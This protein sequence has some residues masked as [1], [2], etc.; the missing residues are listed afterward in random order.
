MTDYPC[1]WWERTDRLSEFEDGVSSPIYRNLVTGVETSSQWLPVGALYVA[2]RLPTAGPHDFPPVGTDGLS[3][4]CVMIGRSGPASMSHWYIEHRASNC[5]MPN[6]DE[7]RCWVRHGTVGD[8]LTVNKNGKTCGAG[9]GS[10]FMDDMR[11]HGFLENGVLV[12]R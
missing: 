9:A 12:Q 6:D 1:T 11:W 3:I 10:V 7:H 2:K 8:K 4:V 5:T